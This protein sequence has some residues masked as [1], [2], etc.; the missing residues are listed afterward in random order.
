MKLIILQVILFSII[1]I[2]IIHFL[3]KQLLLQNYKY[4]I[5]KS[6]QLPNLNSIESGKINSNINEEFNPLVNSQLSEEDMKQYLLD[7]MRD[8]NEIYN[9]KMD[10]YLEDTIDEDI[11]G[12]NKYHSDYSSNELKND[13]ANLQQYFKPVID[14]EKEIKVPNYDM[15]QKRINK[16]NIKENTWEYQNENIMNGAEISNGIHGWDGMN[17]NSVYSNLDNNMQCSNR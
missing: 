14:I 3:I 2:F 16:E 8:N 13:N 6:N 9:N 12:F 15:S 7:Y 4:K 11:K 10:I 1:F 17:T 5:N